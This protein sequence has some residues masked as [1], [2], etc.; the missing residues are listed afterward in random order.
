LLY[1][2]KNTN[3]DARCDALQDLL[4]ATLAASPATLIFSLPGDLKNHDASLFFQVFAAA[5]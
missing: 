5:S 4:R 1:W 3:T 2:Y